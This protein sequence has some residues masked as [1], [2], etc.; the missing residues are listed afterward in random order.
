MSKQI[1]MAVPET[2]ACDL[3][4]LENSSK[5]YSLD[6]AFSFSKRKNHV[7]DRTLDWI[8]VLV[9]AVLVITAFLLS[10][11]GHGAGRALLG[12]S[13]ILYGAVG[14]LRQRI[15]ISPAAELL[16]GVAAVIVSLLFV[17]GGIIVLF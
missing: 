2:T 14:I 9:V 11:A 6:R 16:K 15:L 10:G 13:F 7:S 17:G 1:L 4:I 3:F 12:G 5:E 8:I